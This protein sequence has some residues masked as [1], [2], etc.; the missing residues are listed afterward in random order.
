MEGLVSVIIPA[1]NVGD[2]IGRC[3]ESIL[4]QSYKNF[5]IIVIDDV[6]KDNTVAIVKDLWQKDDRIKLIRSEQNG[7]SAI[8]RQKGI[9][10]S[11]GEMITFVDADDRYCDKKAIEKY[12]SVYKESGVDC[13]MF[14]YQTRHKYGLTI[15]KKFNGHY[16]FYS[17]PEV[18]EAKACNQ[19]PHWHYLWNKCFNGELLRSGTVAFCAELRR[20]QDVRFN[21][22]FL[23]F[24]KNFY[25]MENAY[26]YEYNCANVNQITRKNVELTFDNQKVQYERLKDELHRLLSDYSEIGA[27]VRAK[28][29]LYE[30]F[31]RNA[32]N[33]VLNNASSTWARQLNDYVESDSD[34]Q[35]CKNQLGERTIEIE[36]EVL[37]GVKKKSIKAK[38]KKILRV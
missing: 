28:N 17:A 36:R 35:D 31:Y 11:Q 20:A 27:S 19:A 7:G 37:R 5:E 16:G 8:A 32:L 22:D 4:R 14:E 10:A 18:A 25:V 6:S 23:K 24:A 30:Q 33:L 13:V 15:K 3:I 29:G 38:M 34:Y 26:F 1:Y 2:Y 21:A 12:V 9:N